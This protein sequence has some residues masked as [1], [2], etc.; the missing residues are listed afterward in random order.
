MSSHVLALGGDRS[1]RGPHDHPD[2]GAGGP[3]TRHGDHW[4]AGRYIERGGPQ[5]RHLLD[6][7][8]GAVGCKAEISGG[9]RDRRQT[10]GKSRRDAGGLGSAPAGQ[11]T[12]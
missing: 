12:T 5:T 4:V 8:T 6:C 7:L 3:C 11:P 9:A 10:G 1:A 2:D